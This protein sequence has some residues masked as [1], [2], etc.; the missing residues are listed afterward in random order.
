[1]FLFIL[2]A[3]SGPLVSAKPGRTPDAFEWW[4]EIIL[5]TL[6]GIAT[7]VVSVVALVASRRAT[8]LGHEVE[9]QRDKAEELRAREERERYLRGMS[10]NEAR[11]L[12]AWAVIATKDWHWEHRDLEK[13]GVERHGVTLRQRADVELGQSLVPGAR[14]LLELT[15]IEIHAFWDHLPW[16]AHMPDAAVSQGP[17][18][19]ATSKLLSVDVPSFRKNRMFDRIRAW[20]QDPENMG[21]AIRTELVSAQVSLD[22]HMDYRLGLSAEGLKSNR[23]L[24]RE[25]EDWQ[26]AHRVLR[27]LKLIPPRGDA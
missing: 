3:V 19:E 9:R 6:V 2:A 5:P 23:E 7:V 1:M 24:T 26:A 8:R 12:M 21:P 10:V 27:D 14:D 20:A 18:P 15:T 16:A 13:V 22:E 25:P 11:T 4:S 17:Y